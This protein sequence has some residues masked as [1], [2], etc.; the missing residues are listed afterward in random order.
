MATL[1]QAIG[2]EGGG[3]VSIVGAGG[4]TSLM[5]SLAH[6]ISGAGQSVLTTTTTKIM[7]PSREQSR[8]V[9]LTGSIHALVDNAKKLL[10]KSPHLSAASSRQ[11]TDRGKVNGFPAAFIDGIKQAGLFQWIIVEADGAARRPLKVP[12]EHEPVIPDISNWVIGVVGLKAIG[13]PLGPEWVF[14]HKEYASISGLSQGMPITPA[15]VIEAVIH[16]RGIFKGSAPRAQKILF[17]NDAGNPHRLKTAK[18]LVEKMRERVVDHGISRIVMGSPLE[19]RATVE[20]L[21][22]SPGSI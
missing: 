3:V 4:K 8:H 6:E 10:K 18:I 15:S 17:L 19:K 5:F 2:L 22:M 13:K 21:D 9:I 14:R 7:M 12:A 1:C 16:P 11:P 20:R